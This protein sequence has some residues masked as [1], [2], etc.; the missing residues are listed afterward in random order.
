MT[1]IASLLTTLIAILI[2]L[3]SGKSPS[4]KHRLAVRAIAIL[5]A[6]IA[7]IASLFKNIVIIPAGQVGVMELF[8]S[9]SERPLNPGIHLVNPFAEVEKFSTRLRDIKETV[10]A[11][12]QEGLAFSVDVSLQYKLEPQKAAE[13]YKSIGSNETEIII[14]RFRSIIREVTATYPA[15]A[16]YSTKRQEVANQLRERLSEQIAPLGFIVEDALLRE[17]KL[18]EKLQEAVQEKLAAEQENRKMTFTL[19]KERQEAERKRIEAKGIADSQKIISQGLT[20]PILQL[21]AIEATEKLAA[22]DTT[23]VVIMGSGQGGLPVNIQLDSVLPTQQSPAQ[24][25]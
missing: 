15:E 19:E 8:G 11:T 5:V 22:S 9:V 14:S 2:Y 1:F 20:N 4:P 17:I 23:K 10:E 12:S 21:K 24:G 3:S 7:M 18:P 13:V 16:I 6:G 25:Q